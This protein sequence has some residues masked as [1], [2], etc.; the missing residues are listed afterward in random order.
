MLLVVTDK[1][2]VG[3]SPPTTGTHYWIETTV[4]SRRD[5]SIEVNKKLHQLTYQNIVEQL[6]I[7]WNQGAIEIYEIE[8][9]NVVVKRYNIA[10]DTW[11]D[12]SEFSK[13]VDVKNNTMLVLPGVEGIDVEG[14]TLRVSSEIDA[15]VEGTIFII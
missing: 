12:S 13:Y 5:L 15:V 1:I 7:E 11:M 4:I 2:H 6:N 9:D 8:D 10:N 14:D 3:T